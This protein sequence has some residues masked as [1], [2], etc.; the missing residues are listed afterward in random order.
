M[1]ATTMQTAMVRGVETPAAAFAETVDVFGL[2]CWLHRDQLIA[3]ICEQLDEVADDAEA[4]SQQQREEAEAQITGDMLA[5]ERS[6]S[7]LIW[8]ADAKG[9]V[10]DFRAD[11]SAQAVLGV[12]IV[13]APRVAAGTSVGYAYDLIASGRR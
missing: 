9:D 6:E 3:K 5:V 1:F 8:H 4:L 10:I 2:L 7:G 11:T 12:R 13:T